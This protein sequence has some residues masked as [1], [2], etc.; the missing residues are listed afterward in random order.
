MLSKIWAAIRTSRLL[1]LCRDLSVGEGLWIAPFIILE[2]CLICLIEDCHTTRWKKIHLGESSGVRTFNQLPFP[3][4]A[5]KYHFKKWIKK[6]V[7]VGAVSLVL[8]IYAAWEPL[9][10]R[11]EVAVWRINRKR[12]CANNHFLHQYFLSSFLFSLWGF[13]QHFASLQLI[14]HL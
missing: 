9:Q 4:L 11:V 10:I 7:D 6:L 2:G 12:R 14:S 13:L 1:A 3:L 5:V 8:Y